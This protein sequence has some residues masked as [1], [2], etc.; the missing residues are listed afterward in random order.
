LPDDVSVN[1]HFSVKAQIAFEAALPL[2]LDLDRFAQRA[3]TLQE[4]SQS[5]HRRNR[6]LL[7]LF[8]LL[9]MEKL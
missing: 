3:P 8:D 7:A 2:P 1:R 6:Q 9:A 4:Q 5:Q